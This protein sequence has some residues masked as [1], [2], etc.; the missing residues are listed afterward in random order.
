MSVSEYELNT[1]MNE[2]Y[3]TFSSYAAIKRIEYTYESTFSYMND[4]V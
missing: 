4:I 2:I 3:D 1:Y